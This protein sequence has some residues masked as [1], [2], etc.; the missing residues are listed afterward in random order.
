MSDPSVVYAV[1]EVGADIAEMEI[2]QP[3][4]PGGLKARV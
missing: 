4:S 2:R 3:F 1:E